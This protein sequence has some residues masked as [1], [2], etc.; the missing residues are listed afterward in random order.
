MQPESGNSA[1]QN[2]FPPIVEDEA[3]RG[4]VAECQRDVA[5]IRSGELTTMYVQ[6]VDGSVGSVTSGSL[7]IFESDLRA[8]YGELFPD[9]F[10]QS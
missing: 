2:L 6:T 1:P 8:W 3:T 9:L 10:T 5:R 7:E 4:F